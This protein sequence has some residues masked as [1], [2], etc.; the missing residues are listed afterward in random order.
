MREQHSTATAIGKTCANRVRRATSGPRQRKI[1][2]QEAD[3]K[4]GCQKMG[5]SSGQAGSGATV[6]PQLPHSSPAYHLS[7]TSSF[8]Q[9]FPPFCIQFALAELLRNFAWPSAASR[10]GED[11]K[12]QSRGEFLL[13][14]EKLPALDCLMRNEPGSSFTHRAA[15]ATV[16][17]AA[18]AGGRCESRC[19]ASTRRNP[20]STPTSAPDRHRPATSEY[21]RTAA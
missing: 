21:R 8:R 9:L 17:S 2:R 10:V 12:R 11:D 18:D 15:S 6:R 3:R 4:M 19:P 5:R 14:G 1:D 7:V 20:E 16:S 13:S